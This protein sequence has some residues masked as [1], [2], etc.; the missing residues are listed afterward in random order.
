M[1]GVH[2]AERYG[3]GAT[4]SLRNRVRLSL[5]VFIGSSRRMGFGNRIEQADFFVQQ[6]LSE[7]V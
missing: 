5:G 6:E 1:M 3:V 2:M 7:W 4:A